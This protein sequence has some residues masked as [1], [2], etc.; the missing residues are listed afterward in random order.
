MPENSD[1]EAIFNRWSQSYQ[2]DVSDGKFPFIGYGQTLDQ[3]I[4]IAD[5]QQTNLILDL[6]VGTGALELR[7]PIPQDQIWGVDFSAAMLARA[8]GALPK[9]HL[10]KADLLSID[11]PAEIKQPFDRIL[12]S[13]T[14]HEFNSDQKLAILSRLAADCLADDGLILIADI[15]FTIQNDFEAGHLRFADLWDEEEYYWCAETMIPKVK[16]L[17]LIVNYVQTS[18]C[19]GIYKIQRGADKSIKTKY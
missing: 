7:L 2:E 12:S 6:G 10:L 17:G 14:F 3:L 4:R 11:W 18:D 9:A 15:S 1:R 5:I 8:A 19:A 16:A 13:Y